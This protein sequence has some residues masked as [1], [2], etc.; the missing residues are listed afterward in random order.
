[1]RILVTGATS[2]IGGHLTA[3]LK[4][5]GDDVVTLQR[6]PVSGTSNVQGDITDRAVVARAVRGCGAVVHLAARVGIVGTWNQ[7][8]HTNVI[9]TEV[10]VTEAE[11]AGVRRFV[12]V[13][14]PSVAHGG[15]ALTGAEAAPADPARTRGHYATS[16]ALAEAFALSRHTSGMSVAAI[17]PHL[18][19]GPGDT[20]LVGRIVERAR[21]GRL[22]YVGTGAAMIDSTYITNAVDALEAAID[23]C[24]QAG[25]QA[26][27]VSNGEPRPIADLVHGIVTAHGLDPAVRRIPKPAAFAAGWL[28]E[29]AW[30]RLTLDGEPPITTF[31]AEQ[32]GT[33]HWFD[34]RHTRAVLQWEPAVSIDEGLALL[35]SW[36]RPG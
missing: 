14:S 6:R 12:H 8:H 35:S 25:G 36:A 7:F 11:R 27:V 33:A 2:L 18:V 28:A 19:W 29:R 34:Q 17:R 31:L 32:L 20:Q 9:G 30:D 26:V 21:Q 13:S 23:R 16:K 24:D 10:V 15:E 5:R 1:M 22:A 4:D 3:K